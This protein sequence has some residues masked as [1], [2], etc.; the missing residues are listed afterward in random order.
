M[1]KTNYKN[2]QIKRDFFHNLKGAKGFTDSSIDS[3]AEAVALWETFSNHE[4]FSNFNKTKAVNFIS[5][6]KVKETKTK[7]GTLTLSTQYNYV[8]RIK[9]FF[10]WLT[11]QPGYRNK[12]FRNDIEFLR[13][14]NTDVRIATSGTTKPMPN[15]ED[16]KKIITNIVI[17]D[18]I[19]MRDRAMIS[20]ACITGSRISA[21]ASLKMK[22][23]NEESKEIDQNPGDGV[24]TKNSKKILST[25]FPIGWDEPEKYFL[26][27]FTYLKSKGF[28]SND[29]I[30]PSTISQ[31]N[32][33]GIENKKIVSKKSWND[34]GGARKVFE[35]RCIDAGIHYFNPH[36]F[37]HLVVSIMSKA[38][39]TEEEKRAIS[40]N[41]GH[42]NVGTTFGSY[43]YGSMSGNDAVKIVQKIKVNQEN[44]EGITLT[45]EEA[46]FL[47]DILGKL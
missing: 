26:E 16:V 20:F 24:K 31:L 10:N 34:S 45:T 43:G 46:S 22:S 3:F 35:K 30:F 39:L 5:W 41:L 32:T 19:D 7:A 8:R 14:S 17:K 2:E 40:L 36:S 38:R 23:F 11:E 4:D 1:T 13:L 6:I 12:T 42:E 29:P 25:F 21:I 47:K 28:E 44:N 15:L 18:E 9:K 27:W 33:D 37:R